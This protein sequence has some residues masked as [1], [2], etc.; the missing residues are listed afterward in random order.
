MNR[1]PNGH[2]TRA[3]REEAARLAEGVRASAASRRLSIPLKTLTNRLRTSTADRLEEIGRNQKP[4]TELEA[5][6]QW[7]K[8]K[9]SQA[10]ARPAKKLPPP[11][12]SRGFYIRFTVGAWSML[13][14]K[15]RHRQIET[16]SDDIAINGLA[17]I[18]FQTTII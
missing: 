5:Q 4:Q 8:R 18:I 13:S 11:L 15:G 1:I 7:I 6:L 16:E 2:Y 14:D 9:S 3:A 12:I 10:G 17:G